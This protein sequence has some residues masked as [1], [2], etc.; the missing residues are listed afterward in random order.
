MKHLVLVLCA[1]LLGACEATEVLPAPAREQ[2]SVEALSKPGQATNE[3][4]HCPRKDKARSRHSSDEDRMSVELWYWMPTESIVGS[5][6]VAVR[7][8]IPATSTVAAATLRAWIKGPSCVERAAGII[9]GIP[10]GTR[11]LGVSISDGTATVDLSKDFERTQLGTLYE[12]QLLEQLAWTV[13]QFSTVD[14]VLLKIDGRFKEHYM[15]HGFIV[16]AAHPLTR[17]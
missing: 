8:H 7:R 16:N 10:R 1:A 3:R 2:T 4:R 11:L 13:T 9:D 15:G 17:G 12:G 6:L 14:R 5:D